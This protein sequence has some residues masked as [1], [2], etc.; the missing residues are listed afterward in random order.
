MHDKQ[1][2]PAHRLGPYRT[3]S[4]P[5]APRRKRRHWVLLGIVALGLLWALC[6]MIRSRG[7]RP[8]LAEL[9]KDLLESVQSFPPPE[10]ALPPA[11]PRRPAGNTLALHG[12]SVNKNP[13]PHRPIQHARP[14]DRG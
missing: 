8:G 2:Q 10:G 3:P 13:A 1:G 14:L 9:P 7:E 4:P 6:H 5:E 11:Y 12:V